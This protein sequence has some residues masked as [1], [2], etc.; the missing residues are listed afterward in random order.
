M[1]WKIKIACAFCIFNSLFC[2]AKN[3]ETDSLLHAISTA[4][5]DSLKVNALISLAATNAQLNPDKAT[6][7]ATQA[8]DIS[9]KINF[10]K[11][12]GYSFKW[13][14]IISNSR[15]KYYDALVYSNKSLSIFESLGDDVGI[16]N[17]LNNLG[18]IFFDQGQDSQAIEYYLKSLSIAQQNGNKLRIGSAM[19]NIG[20]VYS[21]NPGSR[22][23]ALEYYV[24]ALPYVL[25][26]KEIESIGIIYT[27][28]GE[29]YTAKNNFQD[30]YYYFNEAIKVLGNSSSTAYTYNDIGKL[31]NKKNIYD[32]AIFYY[33][34]H[35][36]LLKMS[37]SILIWRN[38][39]RDFPSR[40]GPRQHRR[41]YFNL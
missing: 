20:A 3:S 27:N 31:Y 17:L 28:I 39:I 6:E 23:K 38:H 24:K 18:S 1:N 36:I 7:F 21:K 5:D 22:E 11:G 12:L 40:N 37:V 41:C 35:L 16:S 33:Q 30:A 10:Q 2:L 19:A 13:L 8:M 15:G 14:G 26:I 34:T 32:S 9:T 29:I 4:K 25:E